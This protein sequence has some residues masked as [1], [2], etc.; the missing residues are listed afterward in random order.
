MSW[1][2]QMSHLP[3]SK[4]NTILKTFSALLFCLSP[5][6]PSDFWLDKFTNGDNAYYGGKGLSS[7]SNSG[8]FAWGEAYI[9]ESYLQMY[10]SYRDTKFLDKITNQFDIIKAKMTDPNQDGFLG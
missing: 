7:Y 4:R 1:S 5:L 9:L 2:I 6:F 8:T 3:R 10:Q